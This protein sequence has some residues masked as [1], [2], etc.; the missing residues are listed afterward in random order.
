V[1]LVVAAALVGLLT[2]ALVELL[3]TSLTVW[4][5]TEERRDATEVASSVGELVTAD[6]AALTGEARGDLLFD[7]HPFDAD[8]D[9][10]AGLGL[11]RLR[12]VRRASAA[13]LQRLGLDAPEHRRSGALVEVVWAL[14]PGEGDAFLPGVLWR[15]ERVV[16]GGD[17]GASLLAAGFFDGRGYPP[18]DALTEVVGGVLWF[19]ARFASQ[20]TIL[21]DGWELGS[22]LEHAS[23]AWDAWTRGR[24]DAEAFE[25][26]RPAAGTPAADGLPRL[27]RRVRLELELARPADLA[28][29]TVLAERLAED[30]TVLEVADPR[31][32]PE[33]GG[34]VLVDEEWMRVTSITG[35]RARVDRARRGTRRTAHP[36][37]RAVRFGASTVW[38]VPIALHREDW[39]L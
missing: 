3:D 12:L 19:G 7:W 22:R 18:T 28:R 2:V 24:L 37:G 36:R 10:I 21:T 8:G 9:G 29:R 34:H 30:E 6:L 14:L 27:P 11:A 32:L 5:R 25:W 35:S 1:E 26:N 33:P 4:R 39:N 38:E 31:H 15:G 13:E 23:A 20:T 17:P 16:D